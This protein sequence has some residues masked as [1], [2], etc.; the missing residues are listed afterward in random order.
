MTFRTFDIDTNTAGGATPSSTEAVRNTRSRRHSAL[1][2][3][4]SAGARFRG[5][6]L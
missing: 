1:M 5:L 2:S 4:R 3:R 6:G